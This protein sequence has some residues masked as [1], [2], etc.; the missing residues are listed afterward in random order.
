M[1]TETHKGLW[2]SGVDQ[3]TEGEQR[4]GAATTSEPRENAV[5]FRFRIVQNIC[6]RRSCNDK[7]ND[8]NFQKLVKSIMRARMEDNAGIASNFNFF[9]TPTRGIPTYRVFITLSL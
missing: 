5:T 1:W 6:L 3:C 9:F 7:E 4:S 8:V 2:V